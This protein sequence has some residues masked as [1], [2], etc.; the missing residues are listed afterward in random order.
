MEGPYIIYLIAQLGQLVLV[1]GPKMPEP[2]QPAGRARGAMGRVALLP[3]Q[4][5]HVCRLREPPGCLH[6]FLK[7]MDVVA[8]LE[9]CMPLGFEE[10]TKRRDVV[11]S[12]WVQ[13]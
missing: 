10:R 12:E 1:T 6:N 9:K 3:R 13:K 4:H 7:G 2:P 5:R 11:H 8:E